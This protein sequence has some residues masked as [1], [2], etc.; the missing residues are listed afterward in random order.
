MV[1][2]IITLTFWPLSLAWLPAKPSFYCSKISRILHYN[3]YRSEET[4]AETLRYRDT[5]TKINI[6]WPSKDTTEQEM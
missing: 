5:S 3:P 4:K 1:A 6:P 2:M